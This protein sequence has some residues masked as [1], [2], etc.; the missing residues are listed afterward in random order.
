VIRP[1][2]EGLPSA[3]YRD[4]IVAGLRHHGLPEG[5]IAAL[6]GHAVAEA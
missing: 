3:A 5:Y 1:L 6:A 4:A 2:A